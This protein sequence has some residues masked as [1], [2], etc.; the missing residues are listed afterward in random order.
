MFLLRTSTANSRETIF[1]RVRA[2]EVGTIST[3]WRNSA[4]WV[5]QWAAKKRSWREDYMYGEEDEMAERGGGSDAARNYADLPEI[6]SSEN[7]ASST[8]LACAPECECVRV[9]IAW[10]V[11]F[12][13]LCSNSSFDR[14]PFFFFCALNVLM[15]YCSYL[16]ND[17]VS[18]RR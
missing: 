1:A 7:N 9:Y 5:R 4:Q 3:R 15:R 6:I 14:S 10:R 2:Q 13:F 16:L 18:N 11:L 12:F 17:D 8:T